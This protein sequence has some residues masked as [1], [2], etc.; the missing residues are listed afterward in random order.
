MSIVLWTRLEALE[1]R[2]AALEAGSVKKAE[3]LP[4]GGLAESNAIRKAEG[5]RVRA[6]IR[7]IIE[8]HGDAKPLSAR[9]VLRELSSKSGTKTLALRTVQWHLHAIRNARALHEPRSEVD[10]RRELNQNLRNAD[11]SAPERS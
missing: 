3:P 5:E 1:K 9:A 11:R 2:V 6:E 8:T 4:P 10:R 7:R